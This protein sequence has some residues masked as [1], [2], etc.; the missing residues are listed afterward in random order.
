MDVEEEDV[1]VGLETPQ[2]GPESRA[3]LKVKRLVHGGRQAALEFRLARLGRQSLK[4]F[5]SPRVGA[6]GGHALY[7]FVTLPLQG[8]PQGLMA[9]DDRLQCLP[10]RLSGQRTAQVECRRM[11]IHGGPIGVLVQVPKP[12][13]G[14]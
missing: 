1:F 11:G 13:L 5:L 14:R 2:Y 6:L 12:F 10:Q 7:D 4:G 3:H 9:F 8:G